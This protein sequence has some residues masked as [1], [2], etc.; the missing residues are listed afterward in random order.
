M[1]SHVEGPA[2]LR[3]LA[4]SLWGG[5]E[6]VLPGG[7][8]GLISAVLERLESLVGPVTA[9]RVRVPSLVW[10]L[11]GA[12][13]E[14]RASWLVV[15]PYVVAADVEGRAS[16]VPG[17]AADPRSWRGVG[18]GV[19]AVAR[20]PANPDDLKAAALL[21]WEAGARALIVACRRPRVIVVTGVWGYSFW[22]GAPAPVP[23]AC[24]DEGSLPRILRAGRARL[25]VSAGLREV[26]AE[27]LEVTLSEGDSYIAY[28]AHMDRWPGGFSDDTL[29]VAQAIAAAVEA[30]GR[31]GGRLG[32]RL[33]LFT[34]EEHGAPGPAG[35]YWAWGSRHYFRELE[36]AGLSDAVEALVNYDVASGPLRLSGSPQ[37]LASLPRG[38]WSE[39]CC[40][41]PE[42][43]SFQAAYWAGVPTVSIHSLWAGRVR[44]FYHTPDDT[45]SV[46]DWEEAWRAVRLGASLAGSEP[47]WGAFERFILERLGRG[48]LQARRLAHLIVAT[49]SRAGWPRVYRVLS[50][51]ALKAV[52][53]GSYRWGEGDLE[54]A[55]FPE[56]EALRRGGY[57][58]VVV[59]GEERPL[60]QG[61]PEGARRQAPWVLAETMGRVEEALRG[62]IA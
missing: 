3:S 62:L 60:Y 48:P 44:R 43:D 58:E 34:A 16:L 20:E 56:V 1:G 50:R 54:A 23:V 19:V 30:A 61:G 28:S 29:G 59:A 36:A 35:W 26:D 6:P 27:S 22:S 49:A 46:V 21:A 45:P 9:R 32:V 18:D 11:G 41:C 12:G 42:C 52:H 13:V 17:D 39:R 14:P 37:L 7:E 24:I 55:W 25:W 15:P 47:H 10:R 4:E 5:G 33:L 57:D 51:L 31:A 38:G 8:S 53:W 40:E 2:G